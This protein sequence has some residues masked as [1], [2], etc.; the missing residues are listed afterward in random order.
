MNIRQLINEAKSGSAAAQKCLYN[1]I[2][3][4]MMVVC[5]RYVKGSED[6]EEIMLDGFYKFYKNLL[7]FN[8]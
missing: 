3:D 7:S 5:R 8:Y 6:A 4:K 1:L 2:A